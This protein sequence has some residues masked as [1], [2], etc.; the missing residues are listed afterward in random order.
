M[1]GRG[2][3]SL[4]GQMGH[5][6]RDTSGENNHQ[7]HNH[8][9]GPCGTGF[10]MHLFGFDVF[11]KGKAADGLARSI[12]APNPFDLGC[13]GNCKD[14]WTRGKELGVEYDRLYDIPKEGFLEAKRRRE[15][16]EE[17]DDHSL[18]VNRKGNRASSLLRKG[19]SMGLSLGRGSRAGYE[20]V[21]Q[22]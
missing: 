15:M 14:F 2:G 4:A 22:V 19:L 11:T 16:E 18:G 3:I 20:P 21:S 10:L 5:Q 13:I 12:H 6:H 8:S 1:G 9:A 7:R 17:E